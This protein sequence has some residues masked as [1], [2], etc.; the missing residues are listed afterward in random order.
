MKRILILLACLLLIAVPAYAAHVPL[1][2]TSIYVNRFYT[3]DSTQ[4]PLTATCNNS[5]STAA[6]L[7][8]TYPGE[9]SYTATFVGSGAGTVYFTAGL[10]SGSVSLPCSLCSITVPVVA[11]SGYDQV[12]L[13][14][15]GGC[16][17]GGSIQYWQ[18]SI[19][20]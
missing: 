17:N 1:P 12:S 9:T 20:R 11:N 6:A 16:P 7:N 2:I 4:D 13:T 18:Y 3:S 10:S 8:K 14:V 19:S 5:A 15:A